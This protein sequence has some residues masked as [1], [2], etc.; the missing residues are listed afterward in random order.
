MIVPTYTQERLVDEDRYLTRPWQGVIGE[1]L[2]NM[3]KALSNEGFVIPSQSA[4][5]INILI[6]INPETLQPY[7]ADGTIIYDSTNHQFKGMVNGVL[8]TFTLT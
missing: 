3:Q 2:Q 4:A 8:K 7:M 5:N 6:S 1:L